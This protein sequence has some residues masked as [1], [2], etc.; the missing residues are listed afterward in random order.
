MATVDG[1]DALI[2]GRDGLPL[3]PP[4]PG[5]ASAGAAKGKD[6]AAAATAAAAAAAAAPEGPPPVLSPVP[7]DALLLRLRVSCAGTSQILSAKLDGSNVTAALP[8]DAAA[9][10]GDATIE[11]SI[12]GGVTFTAAFATKIAKK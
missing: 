1:I 3:P 10:A 5:K 11:V 9:L 7:A 12:D 8:A 6:A 2:A 4:V